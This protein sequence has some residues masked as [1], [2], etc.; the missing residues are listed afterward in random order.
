[1]N[2]SYRDIICYTETNY[3]LW[4]VQKVKIAMTRQSTLPVVLAWLGRQS[5]F[6]EHS[7]APCSAIRNSIAASTSPLTCSRI[8]NKEF[9]LICQAVNIHARQETHK[10]KEACTYIA[11]VPLFLCFHIHFQP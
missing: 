1:M 4:T 2:E 3:Q 8:C 9:I 10:Q 11:P 5:E 7:S 6:E